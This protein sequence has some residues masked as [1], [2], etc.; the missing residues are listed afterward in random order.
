MGQTNSPERKPAME[1]TLDN[2]VMQELYDSIVSTKSF[3][4]EQAPDVCQQ[5]ITWQYIQACGFMLSVL[6]IFTVGYFLYQI[7]KKKECADAQIG[8]GVAT[9]IIGLLFMGVT[10]VES[11]QCLQAY[12]TPKVFILNQIKSLLVNS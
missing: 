5:M 3:V 4:I 1:Q 2:K 7:A 9:I 12:V 10:I 11:F 6:A 8:I